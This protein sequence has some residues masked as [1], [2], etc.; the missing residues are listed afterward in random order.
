MRSCAVWSVLALTAI[1]ADGGRLLAQFPSSGAAPVARLSALAGQPRPGEAVPAPDR[2]VSPVQAL[3]A[4][5]GERPAEA[6]R[7]G[8]GEEEPDEIETDRDSFTPA[9]TTAG[10]GRLIAEYAYSFID[11]RG[12]KETHS[13]P[14]L[15]L[16]YGVTE[17]V[18]L[19]LG[20]NYE[21]GGAGNETS[22][23]GVSDEDATSR[24]GVI[25]EY[26]LAYGAKV[27][28]TKQRRWL[29][30]SAFIVQG[31]T[32]TGG[33]AGAS[34]A[35]QLVAT[36]VAGW[37]FPNRWKF[38]AAIRYGTASEEGDH[39]HA[40]GPSAV[41]KVPFGEKWAGHVEYF[42]LFTSG[43]AQNFTKHFVSPGL[44]YLVTPN[45]EVGFRLGWGL[46]D[47]SARFFS[48]VGVGWRF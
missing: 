47:R 24:T 32:P 31:F 46:N 21:V 2:R 4:M 19:R 18:E 43:K 17:R 11:N 45:F 30:Q 26:T 14:E 44:H 48:N 33:S 34:T 20:W 22:G 1:L 25:R 35:T 16:R 42:G 28:V 39:F 10:R 41:V 5:T 9:T 27:G 3:E 8:E 13:V 29:P 23:S 40:W 12:I 7:E 38:D 6:G 37:V 36:Y 15:I